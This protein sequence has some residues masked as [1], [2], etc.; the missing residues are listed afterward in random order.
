M[1]G[2]QGYQAIDST[3]ASALTS[4]TFRRIFGGLP[5]AVAVVTTRDASGRP[6]GTTTNTVTAVSLSP[7]ILSVCLD[8]ASATLA[9]IRGHG[10]FAVNFLAD[11]GEQISRVLAQKSADKF[12]QIR[13]PSVEGVS[14]AP[15]FTEDVVA[16]A[17]CTLHSE[18]V[19]GDHSIVVGVIHDGAAHERTP[20]MYHR[21]AYSPW[22]QPEQDGLPGG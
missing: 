3:P 16:H 12:S 6:T 17:E 4:T 18:I 15:V 22:Q 10:S 7:P 14:G 19:M 13:S 21:G 2:Q 1:N 11:T 5:T 20:L 9:A 8:R